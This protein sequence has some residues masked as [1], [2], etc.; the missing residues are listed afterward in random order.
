MLS[1]TV[2]GAVLDGQ[3]VLRLVAGIFGVANW[4]WI[5]LF[6]VEV[7]GPLWSISFEITS[8]VLLPIGFLALFALGTRLPRWASRLGWLAL[9]GLTLGAHL[10][11]VAWFPIDN[12]RRSWD[13]GLVGGA[14]TWMPLFNPFS[15]F[16]MFA[17]GAFAAGIQLWLSRYRSWIFDV[18]VLLSIAFAVWRFAEQ[19]GHRMDTGYGWLGI[20]YGFP[21]FPIAVAAVL[22]T[23]P[24]SV[25]IGRL[26]DNP[27]TTFIARISFG[28]Y[29]WHYLIM[30]LVRHFWD[31]AFTYNGQRDPDLFN[32]S[33]AITVVATL[34]AAVASFYLVER[35]AIRWARN[36]EKRTSTG[37]IPAPAP[38]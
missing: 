24:S 34:V 3:L 10:L 30:E 37:A 5:T 14:K 13:F 15:F 36:L 16:A 25:L 31:P 2:F 27:L 33:M 23:T 11:F 26:L 32:A 7:N 8:Y 9:I 17:I 12:V 38:A 29:I 1:I 21:L 22:A 20:P 4:H 6:P 35:P 18:L 19:A 28:I